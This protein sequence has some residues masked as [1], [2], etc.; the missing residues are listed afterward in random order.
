MNKTVALLM[1]GWSPE[2]EVSLSSGR[3][4]AKALADHG[5]RV[6]AIDVGR[7]LPALLRSPRPAPRT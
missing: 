4:C 5:Y 6:K 2:R 3:E 7:D 1:G